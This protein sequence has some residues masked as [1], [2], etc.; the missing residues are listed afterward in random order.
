MKAESQDIE[1]LVQSYAALK[2][3]E[4]ALKEEIKK[5]KIAL[6]EANGYLH[7]E[8]GDPRREAM[9]AQ[10]LQKASPSGFLSRHHARCLRKWTFVYVP[11]F[12]EWRTVTDAWSH[13]WSNLQKKW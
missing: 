1:K 4:V 5:N 11:A 12:K 9:D 2:R 7:C 10:L 13:L 8:P 6:F 3:Q